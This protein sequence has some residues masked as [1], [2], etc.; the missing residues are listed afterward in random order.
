MKCFPRPLAVLLFLLINALAVFA[1][2]QK[3][4]DEAKAFD[5]LRQKAEEL[6]GRSPVRLKG[7]VEVFDAGAA[8]P[9]STTVVVIERIPP[10]RLYFWFYWEFS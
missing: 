6:I 7:T 8:G 10:D 2:A 5:E 1:Q 3:P 9:K 4:A